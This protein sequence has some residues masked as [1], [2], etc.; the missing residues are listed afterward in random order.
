MRYVRCKPSLS[1]QSLSPG[2]SL[3]GSPP[4]GLGV[5]PKG[6]ALG[7]PRAQHTQAQPRVLPRQGL[8]AWSPVSAALLPHRLS[9]AGAVSRAGP[10]PA[11]GA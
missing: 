3:T 10:R 11:D 4:R 9:G 1:L 8:C 7:A 2:L 6:R 5:S